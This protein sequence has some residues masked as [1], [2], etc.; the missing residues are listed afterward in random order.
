MK[1]VAILGS[2]GSIGTQALEV[3]TQ[4]PDNFQVS[5][6]TARSNVD[7]LVTQALQF[8]PEHV[9]VSDPENYQQVADALSGLD[10]QVHKG[11]EPLGEVVMFDCVDIVLTALVGY[12]G[13]VPTMNALQAGKDIALANKETLVVAGELITDLA[14]LNIGR[15]IYSSCRSFWL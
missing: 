14:S 7:L 8:I 12:A 11:S 10:T 15:W 3:I 13:L 9:V 2:T 1:R 4:H 6:L 5:V